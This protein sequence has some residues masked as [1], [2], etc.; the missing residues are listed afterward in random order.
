MPV[1]IGVVGDLYIGGIAVGRGYLNNVE[2][3]AEL[4][5][6]DPFSQK[7]GGR[8]YKTRDRARY[9]PDGLIEF[10]GRSDNLI[11]I[12]GL[13][14]EPGE[15]EAVLERHP[16]IRETVVLARE[17][18]SGNKY[19][20]AYIVPTK[21]QIPTSGEL[22]TWLKDKIPEYMIPT[23]FVPLEA[24]PLNS[25]G[26]LD[27]GALPAPE[28]ISPELKSTFVKART[29]LEETIATI[30]SQVLEI[31]QIGIYDNFFALGGHSLLAM[32]VISRLRAT[33]QVEVPLH[34]FLEAPTVA[35]LAQLLQQPQAS[36]AKSRQPELRSI[37]REAY[38][39][40]S[41]STSPE[42]NSDLQ[43]E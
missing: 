14:I 34:S 20:V 33:F 26:K 31:E 12:R 1:P 37:S 42:S 4:F 3:T 27:R 23:V 21:D 11:K 41:V 43:E 32:L 30:W 10:L 25:N 36:D 17:T 13:R 7:P 2:R 22:R 8:L 9:L 40:P 5:L 18:T 39:V 38:R 29:S 35:H 24:M 6:P 19:L 28:Q 15:I 16:A